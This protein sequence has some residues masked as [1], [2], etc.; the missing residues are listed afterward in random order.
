[1]SIPT[2]V[3]DY[4]FRSRKEEE[5]FKF[6]F[7]SGATADKEIKDNFA[8]IHKQAAA[9]D[10]DSWIS[11]GPHGTLALIIVLDQFSRNI[12]RGSAQAFAN[13]ARAVELT[14]K[15]LD[16]GTLDDLDLYER[17]FALLPLM[18]SEDLAVHDKVG[19]QKGHAIGD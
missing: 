4:W 12:H 8:S 11:Q 9:G 14:Q 3:L 17:L 13:D 1:M 2:Q 15:L 6:W 18:H 19:S 5:R 10:K 16:D 7:T